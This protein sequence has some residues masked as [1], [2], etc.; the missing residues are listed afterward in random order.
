MISLL[1]VKHWLR[2]QS[3]ASSHPFPSPV[4]LSRHSCIRSSLKPSLIRTC[5]VIKYLRRALSP[6]RASNGVVAVVR[7]ISCGVA[8]H[9]LVLRASSSSS[10]S[11]TLSRI[12]W[13]ISS[14]GKVFARR[15]SNSMPYES[16]RVNHKCKAT[17]LTIRATS[18]SPLSCSLSTNA[19]RAAC[20]LAASSS[21][22]SSGP[23]AA[24]LVGPCS[25]VSALTCSDSFL[26]P[27]GFSGA[28]STGFSTFLA[29]T[30][31]V[32]NPRCTAYG[33]V[34]CTATYPRHVRLRDSFFFPMAGGIRV[35]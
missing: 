27:V 4:A 18:F 15:L 32:A 7:C 19:C 26:S 31:V 34:L 22:S 21:Q 17:T 24:S 12:A 11:K 14:V 33:S 29:G 35:R 16:A 10:S 1:E 30:E 13:L 23:S 5:Q 6:P 28:S 9:V 8:R 3:R 2:T 20:S 25:L